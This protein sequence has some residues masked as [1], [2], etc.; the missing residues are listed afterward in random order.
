M[1]G[2]I[3]PANKPIITKKPTRYWS[4]LILILLLTTFLIWASRCQKLPSL[5]QPPIITD[6][7]EEVTQTDQTNNPVIEQPDQNTD[8]PDETETTNTINNDTVADTCQSNGYI[9]KS[10]QGVIQLN[11]D[12]FI[13]FFTAK[14]AN[15]NQALQDI[16]GLTCL[17]KLTILNDNTYN[18]TDLSSLAKLTQ[19]QI[20]EIDGTTVTDLTPLSYL[21][22]LKRLMLANSPITNLAG[23]KNLTNLTSL[24]LA[25][26]NKLSDISALRNLTKLIDLELSGT[27]IIDL[28]PITSLNN[29]KTLALFNTNW[30]QQ[31][32]AG[33]NPLADPN[34]QDKLVYPP[35]I[36]ALLTANPALQISWLQ[37]QIG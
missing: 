14:I 18:I 34:W 36:K 16:R 25:G 29:L 37:F 33:V 21:T 1:L 19:L 31:V 22:N 10:S 6:Y 11:E 12:S 15:G 8:Q 5:D 32:L 9:A 7:N 35:E 2:I 4:V 23:I 13:K 30:S 24:N 3:P 20:L 28:S 17:E 27:N 26:D